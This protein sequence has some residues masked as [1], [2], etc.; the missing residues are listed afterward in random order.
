MIGPAT[1]SFLC[2]VTIGRGGELA[3]IRQHVEG[4]AGGV[5][6]ISGEAG[7]GKTR[8]V[9]EA[10]AHAAELDFLMLQGAC[11]EPD[12]AIPYAPILDL[13]RALV[14]DDPLDV[15]TRLAGSLAADLARL[16]RDLARPGTSAGAQD[17]DPEMEKRRLFEALIRLLRGLSAD[18]PLLVVIEDLHWSDDVSLDFLLHLARWVDNRP[19]RLLLSY[20][21]EEVQPHLRHLLAELDR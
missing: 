5:L 8:L 14:D 11:F 7:I 18:R 9:R 6:L 3:A 15:I 1:P 17:R 10:A 4:T 19:I 21:P 20:R 2:P 16:A 12:R 13:L